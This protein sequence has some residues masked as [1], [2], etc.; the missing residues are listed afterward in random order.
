M[1]PV[2]D[3]GNV[4]IAWEPQAA[5]RHALASDAEIDA[6]LARLDF[7]DWNYEQDRGRSRTEAVA[8]IAAQH[9]RHADLMDQFFDHFPLTIRN[10]INESWDILHDLRARGHKPWA[11]TNWGAETWPH[12]LR[13]HPELTEVFQGIVVS[14]HEATSNPTA[15]FSTSCATAPDW[16]GNTVFSST[17]APPMSRARAPQAGRR[18]ISPGHQPCAPT[19]MNGGFYERLQLRLSR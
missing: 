7:Y 13:L 11:L 14:G 9:P 18:I 19:C 2:F 4:L 12:A 5:F 3:L 10:K 1:T 15:R 16:T 8:A 17:T 6:L